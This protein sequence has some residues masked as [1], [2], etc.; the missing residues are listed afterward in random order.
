LIKLFFT[1]SLQE[2]SH[3]GLPAY[4]R[5]MGRTNDIWMML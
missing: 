5:H 3:M 2:R 1:A 4:K